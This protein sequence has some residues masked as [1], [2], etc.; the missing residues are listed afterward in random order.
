MY[1]FV[2]KL[3]SD[4]VE[5]ITQMSR[6]QKGAPALIDSRGYVYTMHRVSK[7]SK[8]TSWRC[9]LE[10]TGCKARCHTLND[11]ILSFYSDHNHAPPI[12]D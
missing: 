1:L 12:S 2:N 7:V 4:Y 6:T 10:A 9:R 8:K 11:V 5:R 3:I